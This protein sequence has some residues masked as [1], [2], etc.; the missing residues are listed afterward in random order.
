MS[1]RGMFGIVEGGKVHVV[2]NHCNSYPEGLGIILQE[3]Y[4]TID[5]IKM[6]MKL[7]D[8]C[9]LQNTVETSK[10]FSGEGEELPIKPRVFTSKDEMVKQCRERFSAEYFY[11]LENG[12]WHNCTRTC[13]HELTDVLK[14]LE[15]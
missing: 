15:S 12:K 1:T 5:K 8:F 14:E 9:S 3:N 13:W 6:T 10:T 4:N 2:Y 11:L 7:G